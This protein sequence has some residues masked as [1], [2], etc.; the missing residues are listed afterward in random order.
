[1]SFHELYSEE[2]REAIASAYVDRGIHPARRVVELAAAGELEWNGQPLEP[3]TTNAS[4][5]RSLGG[6]LR[7]RRTGQVT[8]SLAAAPPATP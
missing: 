2:Q 3:F 1:L 4:T 7:R 5:V 8:S 6:L